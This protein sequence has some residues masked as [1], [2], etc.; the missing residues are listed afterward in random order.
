MV[1]SPDRDVKVSVVSY[2]PHSF[3]ASEREEPV[4]A[5]A[6]VVDADTA[7]LALSALRGQPQPEDEF[8]LAAQLECALAEVT[9]NLEPADGRLVLV[10]AGSRPPHPRGADV[11]APSIIRCPHK[12]DWREEAGKLASL[13][14]ATL[15]AFT[16][17]HAFGL[18]P[19][20]EQLGRNAIGL[21][22]GTDMTRFATALGLGGDA[23]QVPFP[24]AADA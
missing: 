2:G 1:N 20:W 3:D 18:S 16:E 11:H 4:W 19:A 15:G 13:P 14:G 24:L 22:T 23:Q 10:T 9:Q 5:R 6:W 12:Y 21:V 8:T 7:L 17:G